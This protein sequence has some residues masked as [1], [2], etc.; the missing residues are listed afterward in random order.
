[1]DVGTNS[2]GGFPED[3]LVE[4]DPLLKGVAAN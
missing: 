1:V 4:V 2:L 3:F